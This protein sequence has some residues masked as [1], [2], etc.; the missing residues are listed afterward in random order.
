MNEYIYHR[1]TV[2]KTRWKYCCWLSRPTSSVT[3][4]SCDLPVISESQKEDEEIS[5]YKSRLKPYEMQGSSI[6][7][8]LLTTTPRPYIPEPL[9]RKIFDMFHDIS[10]PGPTP[11]SKLIKARYF[12]LDMDRNIRSLCKICLRC[13]STWSPDTLEQK[14][15]HSLYHLEDLKLYI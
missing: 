10:H 2:H 4:D 12:W 11:A 14:L 8:D 9:R 5:I 13:H 1:R 3:I 7:C 6:W 15:H